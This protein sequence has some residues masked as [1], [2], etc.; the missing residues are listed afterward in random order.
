MIGSVLGGRISDRALIRIRKAS[1]KPAAAEQRLHTIIIPCICTPFPFIIYAWL[2][3][4]KVFIAGPVVILFFLG[5]SQFWAYSAVLSYLVDSNR[6]RAAA[7][8]SA[9]SLFRGAVAC[10]ASQVAGPLQQR[11]G[12]GWM[13][14]GWALV[15][16]FAQV[17]LMI[18]AFRGTAWR[19]NKAL[20][21]EKAEKA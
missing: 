14:T 18:V 1:G 7:A 16:A 3:D 15:L 10:V 4:Y 12:D 8:I 2:V 19:E 21:D 6:G 20:A 5:L 9:N 13:T 17:L 11:M